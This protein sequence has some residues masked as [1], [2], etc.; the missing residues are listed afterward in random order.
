M[1]RC[2]F[3]PGH[4]GVFHASENIF[5]LNSSVNAKHASSGRNGGRGLA[6]RFLPNHVARCP[7]NGLAIACLA[8]SFIA[9]FC[10]HTGMLCQ[11]GS[12]GQRRLAR[13]MLVSRFGAWPMSHEFAVCGQ[14]YSCHAVVFDAV[15]FGPDCRNRQHASSAV[16]LFASGCLVSIHGASILTVSRPQA[17]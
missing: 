3:A 10:S 14:R 8:E 6:S 7:N 11:P 16:E 17:L 2:S 1:R 13:S 15:V 9:I 5:I 4:A 12:V